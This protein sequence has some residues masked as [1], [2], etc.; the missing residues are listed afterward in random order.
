MKPTLAMEATKMAV[1]ETEV[2]A[3]PANP[4]YL[5]PAN[6]KFVNPEWLRQQLADLDAKTGEKYVLEPGLTPEILKKKMAVDLRA[7]GID[8]GTIR[9]EQ[10]YEGE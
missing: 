7:R 2:P 9:Y 10:K 8:P 1:F 5:D 3:L 4:P 6:P